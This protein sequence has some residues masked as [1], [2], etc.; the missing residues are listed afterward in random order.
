MIDGIAFHR[1]AD[2]DEAVATLA[3]LGTDAMVLGG[4]T[5]MVPALGRRELATKAI[6]DPS[7]LGLDE[8][9]AGA[10]GGLSL[11]ARVTYT[12]LLRSPFVAERVPLLRTLAGGITGGAQIR[13]QGT[14]GGS[15]CHANPASDIPACLCALEAR[16]TLL[17]PDGERAV[18]AADF[19][20]DAFATALEPGELLT[21]IDIP[22][23]AAA[24]GYYKL[25]LAES[26]WPIATAVARRDG[27]G[28]RLV[29]G[30]VAGTPLRLDRAGSPENGSGPADFD[31]W[32]EAA[33]EDPYDDVLASGEYRRQVAGPVARR[34][35]KRM[36]DRDG[37]GR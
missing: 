2:R 17:G 27:A 4:G 6:V 29:L 7:R 25:K 34:A 30:G 5:M 23:A 24:F 18:A 20:R 13:N 28:A 22:A 19:F 14:I 16:L 21:R 3:A 36:E 10:D 35:W 8:V 1:P 31:A 26:S 33:I 15:A 32:V 11:G 37:G 12:A 9:R